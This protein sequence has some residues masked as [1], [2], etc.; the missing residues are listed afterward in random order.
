MPQNK[1]SQV[2]E[3]KPLAETPKSAIGSG[4]AKTTLTL[5]ERIK[6][7]NAN[8]RRYESKVEARRNGF[9]T[10]VKEKFNRLGSSFTSDM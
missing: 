4:A 5:G 2:R 1:K 7:N 10:T 6:R 3:S 8:M 9:K